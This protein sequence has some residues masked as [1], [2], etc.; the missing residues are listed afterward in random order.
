MA[1]VTLEVDEASLVEGAARQLVATAKDSLGNAITGRVV[2][3]MS[4]DRFDPQ[5]LL[6]IMTRSEI[7][8]A[9]R[10]TANVLREAVLIA[11]ALMAVM[12]FAGCA[13]TGATFR[14]GVGE[15]FPSGLPVTAR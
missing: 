10:A 5:R 11:I 9:K 6:R 13:T 15:S 3:W 14:S 4:T 1:R 2:G 8:R 7:R 12:A